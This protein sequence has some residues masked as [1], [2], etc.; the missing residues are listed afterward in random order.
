MS[1]RSSSGKDVTENPKKNTHSRFCI[2]H[3]QEQYMAMK[4]CFIHIYSK[5]N[6]ILP[7]H[8][9]KKNSYGKHLCGNCFYRCLNYNN[10]LRD[11]L[12]Y[13]CGKYFNLFLTVWQ[14]ALSG[15]KAMWASCNFRAS[16]DSWNTL[17]KVGQRVVIVCTACRCSSSHNS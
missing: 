9:K 7:D 13:L 12:R 5:W 15:S 3:V 6:M 14:L 11:H 16:V 10:L 1:S 4:S 2:I 8:L 17:E